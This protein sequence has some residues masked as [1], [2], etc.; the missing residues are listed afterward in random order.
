MTNYSN[1]FTLSGMTGVFSAAVITALG[2]VSGTAGPP[3]VNNVAAAAP[4][5]GPATTGTEAEVAYTAQTGTIRYAPMQPVP[6][7]K[8]TATNT[9]PL[10]PTSAVVLASTYLPIP[11]IVSTITVAQTFSVAS[12]ANTV[13]GLCVISLVSA[14]LK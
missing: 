9:A 13:S 5:A 2:T 6:G 11:S 1:R 3:T 4:A 8:I 10:F 12:H 7:T 14:N